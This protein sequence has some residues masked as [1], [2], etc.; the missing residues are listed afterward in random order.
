MCPLPPLPNPAYRGSLIGLLILRAQLGSWYPLPQPDPE[1]AL[2]PRQRLSGEWP[3]ADDIYPKRTSAAV[4]SGVVVCFA[5]SIVDLEDGNYTP[6]ELADASRSLSSH[7]I[8]SRISQTCEIHATRALQR[9]RGGPIGLHIPKRT[10][11]STSD[12]TTE[13]V[14]CRRLERS[15]P[16]L[17]DL[18]APSYV[19]STPGLNDEPLLPAE[20]PRLALVRAQNPLLQPLLAPTHPSTTPLLSLGKTTCR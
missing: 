16:P 9:K 6:A 7:D 5:L 13:V 20:P 19:L 3:S 15:C 2:F 17:D 1:T 12:L 18:S 4:L 14:R 10:A 11:T 8:A